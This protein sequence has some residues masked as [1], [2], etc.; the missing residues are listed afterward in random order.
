[1]AAHFLHRTIFCLNVAGA[2]ALLPYC[3]SA[4]DRQHSFICYPDNTLITHQPGSSA[5]CG[6]MAWHTHFFVL[7]AFG[8]FTVLTFGWQ[9]LTKL[10]SQPKVTASSLDTWWATYRADVVSVLIVVVPAMAVTIATMVQQGYDSVPIYGMCLVSVERGFFANFYL[11]YIVAYI[12]PAT[13]FLAYGIY[14]LMHTHGVVGT[15]RWIRG[16]KNAVKQW[17]LPSASVNTVEEFKRL[18]RL[19]LIYILLVNVN[20]IFKAAHGAHLELTKKRW[21]EQIADHIECVTF[22]CNPASCPPLPTQSAT[23]YLSHSVVSMISIIVVSSWVF[24]RRFLVNVP[25]FEALLEKLAHLGKLVTLN[26]KELADSAADTGLREK[27]AES[28]SSPSNSTSTVLS[29]ST[30]NNNSQP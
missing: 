29:V 23:L 30:E 7:I 26:S 9:Q 17:E 16:K 6:Y 5:K 28:R 13:L 25:H 11:W 8:Y 14:T 12:T 24:S 20:Q 3:F 19:L 2:L 22:R 10:L 15:L 4:M 27:Q 21:M 1:M 18:S